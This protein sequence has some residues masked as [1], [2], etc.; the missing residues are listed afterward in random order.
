MDAEKL[1]DFS[2][3]LRLTCITIPYTDAGENIPLSIPVSPPLAG[4]FFR[5]KE[6]FTKQVKPTD[7]GMRP[8]KTTGNPGRQTRIYALNA[9][10]CA[11]CFCLLTDVTVPAGPRVLLCDS[12]QGAVTDSL[13]A[14]LCIDLVTACALCLQRLSVHRAC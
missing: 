4:L 6:E 7:M 3:V 14:N 12:L 2:R 5:Y 8:N 9:L 10:V 1:D 11:Q 13:R